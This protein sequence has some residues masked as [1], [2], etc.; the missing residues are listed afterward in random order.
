MDG[1]LAAEQ[2][3][4]AK[5]A[6]RTPERKDF[7]LGQTSQAP[8]RLPRRQSRQLRPQSC[9]KKC[10]RADGCW[11]RWRSSKTTSGTGGSELKLFTFVLRRL[12]PGFRLVAL[13]QKMGPPSTL[14]FSICA[15]AA[16]QA[17]V[18][19]Y[20]ESSGVCESKLPGGQE[21]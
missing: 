14:K 15:A 11:A 8:L 7:S 3:A 5:S 12:L 20:D 1:V 6:S 16:R 9:E 18:H 10:L 19:V 13:T 17:S 4:Q 2:K 21:L